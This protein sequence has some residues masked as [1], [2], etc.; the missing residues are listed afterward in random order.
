MAIVLQV[1]TVYAFLVYAFTNI[2]IINQA[3]FYTLDLE[4]ILV[5]QQTSLPQSY[6]TV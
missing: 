4:V 2:R 6:S 3:I 5:V 1:Y